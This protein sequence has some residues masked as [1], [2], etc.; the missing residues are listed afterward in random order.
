MSVSKTALPVVEGNTAGD[1]YTV[2]LDSQPTA[3]VVVTVAGHANKDVT[4]T[5]TSLTFTTS[6]WDTAQTVTVTAGDDADRENDTVTLTHVAASADSNYQG[7]MIDDVT[8]TVNDD[9]NSITLV[10]NTENQASTAESPQFGALSFVTGPNAVEFTIF[11]VEIQLGAVSGANISVRIRED[12]GGEPATGEPLA[13]LANPGRLRG[14]L[15]TFTAPAGTTL[16]PG[17]D[18]LA[19]R[20]RGNHRKPG[21]A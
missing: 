5:P 10:T 14:G 16:A 8:V 19:K 12:D 7:I 18:L 4:P 13:T 3:E 15:N 6:D 1:S 11:Q 20:A 17:K 21:R 2:V 9:D